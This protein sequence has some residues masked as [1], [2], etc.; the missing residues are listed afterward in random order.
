MTHQTAIA[1]ADGVGWNHMG[2]WAWAGMTIGWIL[3]AVVVV[4]IIRSVL[5][6]GGIAV[7]NRAVELLDERYARGE[8]EHAEYTKR[9]SELRK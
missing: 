7:G 2:G 3:M 8:I 5:G 1:I 4:V 9:K 6:K